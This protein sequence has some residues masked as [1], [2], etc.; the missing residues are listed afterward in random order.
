MKT[1]N[2]LKTKLTARLIW[3]A[4]CNPCLK[5]ARRGRNLRAT[6]VLLPECVARTYSGVLP[7]SV[8]A[9]MVMLRPGM[10]ICVRRD[11]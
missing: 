3:A 8:R 6:V 9:V 11:S 2:A 7:I 1:S 4:V 5:G 10:S